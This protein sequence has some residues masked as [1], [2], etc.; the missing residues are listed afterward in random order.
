MQILILLELRCLASAS[1][2]FTSSILFLLF[3]RFLVGKFEIHMFSMEIVHA[4]FRIEI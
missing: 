1:F 4:I 2:Y 3:L